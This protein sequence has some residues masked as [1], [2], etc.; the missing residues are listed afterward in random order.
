MGEV[1]HSKGPWRTTVTDGGFPQMIFSDDGHG[2]PIITCHND[3]L[4]W[5]QSISNAALVV[6]A[7]NSHYQLLA[8]AKDVLEVIDNP[9][10]TD[11]LKLTK[12]QPNYWRAR[13][14]DEAIKLGEVL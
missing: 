5:E 7:V 3:E 8:A 14:L 10:Y 4:G 13:A 11:K 9:A 1:K 6:R 2:G 12:L